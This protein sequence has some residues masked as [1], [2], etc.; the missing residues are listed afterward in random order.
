MIHPID[1]RFDLERQVSRLLCFEIARGRYRPGDKLPA[2]AALAR[3]LL[4]NPRKVEAAYEALARADLVDLSENGEYVVREDAPEKARHRL[5]RHA[6]EDL[7]TIRDELRKAGFSPDEIGAIFQRTL[8]DNE[9]GR[10]NA[11]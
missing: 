1:E 5:A 11:C 9:D 6:E 3:E 8:E 4:I 2:L 7:R 10:S